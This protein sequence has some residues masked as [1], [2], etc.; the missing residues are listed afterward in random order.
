MQRFYAKSAQDAA[1][2]GGFT[3]RSTGKIDRRL[4]DR[5]K[6]SL[7]PRLPITISKPA[8]GVEARERIP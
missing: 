3:S 2:L 7:F 4:H 6:S 5:S 1:R 8:F